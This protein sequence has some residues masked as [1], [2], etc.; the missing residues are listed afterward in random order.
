MSLSEASLRDALMA[1]GVEVDPTKPQLVKDC[2]AL[3]LRAGLDVEMFANSWEAQMLNES[4]FN[5]LSKVS[6]DKFEE[7]KRK[8]MQLA[9]RKSG[10]AGIGNKASSYKT[11]SPAKKRTGTDAFATANSKART[12][13]TKVAKLNLKSSYKNRPQA[14]RG[15]LQRPVHNQFT[16]HAQERKIYEKPRCTITTTQ[17]VQAKGGPWDQGLGNYTGG[18]SLMFTPPAVRAAVLEDRLLAVGKMLVEKHG[19]DE[20]VPV[21][22]MSQAEIVC[23]GRVCC[24]SDGTPDGTL[25]LSSVM[26]EGSLADSGGAR[27]KLVLTRVKECLLFPGQ[28]VAVKGTNMLGTEFIVNQIYS[29]AS[30]SPSS[31]AAVPGEEEEEEEAELQGQPL[32]II[33]AAGPFCVVDN[34]EYLPLSDLSQQVID[35]KADVLIL[36]GPFVDSHNEQVAT[37]NAVTIDEDDTGTEIKNDITFKG[38]LETRVY[39]EIDYMLEELPHLQVIIVPSPDD[40]SHMC[41]YPQEPFSQFSFLN[42][43]LADEETVERMKRVVFM[44]NPSKFEINGMSVAVNTADIL[45]HMK[46]QVAKKRPAEAPKKH[47]IEELALQLL[48]QRS[49]YPL[50]PAPSGFALDVTTLGHTTLSKPRLLIVSSKFKWFAREVDDTLVLNPGRLTKGLSAGSFAKLTIRPPKQGLKQEEIMVEHFLI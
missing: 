12:R 7:R 11:P 9:R 33:S 14:Q 6:L 24:E 26:L 8:K 18:R 30:A 38:L 28:I 40:A 46:S 16:V 10:A 42:N 15:Q 37:G 32:Q 39:P 36:Q 19:L 20:H 48:Q 47:F 25:N 22:H 5:S 4:M 31:E 21:G 1:V 27:I 29:D 23:V 13:S 17:A 45:L 43:D 2:L 49:M 3:C 34:L 50:F 44:A 35:S 41:V